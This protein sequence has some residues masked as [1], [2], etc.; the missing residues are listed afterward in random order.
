MFKKV[1]FTEI[2]STNDV[3]KK[4]LENEKDVRVSADFQ[5]KGKG[6]N[7]KIWVGGKAQ[8]I[9]VSF[10]FKTEDGE[11]GE[12][13]SKYQ[14]LGSIAVLQTLQEVAPN[15]NFSLKYPNDVIADN[16][17]QKGKISGILCEHEFM[18]MLCFKTVIG[19]GINVGQ[20]IFE[21][22][23]ENVPVSLKTFKI[24]VEREILLQKLEGNILRLL[25]EP[26]E[27]ILEMWKKALGILDKKVAV[28]G[29]EGE[30]N[31][32]EIFPD[33]RLKVFKND[34]TRIIDNGDSI[35]YF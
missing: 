20:E 34:E 8:N 35:R 14:M 19:I 27:Q 11:N 10:G 32:G 13:I 26:S 21:K 18:G 16:G 17:Q 24:E 33:G 29:L 5:T 6:R 9:Y 12:E 23:P 3:A 25:K 22:V 1:H 31:V 28:K 4:L 7:G 2:T 15:I 30:W